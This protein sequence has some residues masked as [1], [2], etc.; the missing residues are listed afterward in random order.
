MPFLPSNNLMKENS[1]Y[2]RRSQS[3]YVMHC[4]SRIYKLEQYAW[5][6][7]TYL[8]SLLVHWIFYKVW[9]AFYFEVSTSKWRELREN[10]S[11]T[12]LF[13]VRIFLCSDWIRRFTR[14]KCP[15]KELFMV[16]IS[17][18]SDWIRRFI[19]EK[20]SK[21]K[22]FLVRIFLYSDQK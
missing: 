17:L 18:Y 6:S 3:K 19:C 11:N 20:C 1:P 2:P 13:L 21:T 4:K 9:R 14:E 15:N 12:E 22:L 10:C 7:K 5:K 16:R 8:S